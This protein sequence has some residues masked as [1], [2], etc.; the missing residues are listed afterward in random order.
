MYLLDLTSA[1]YT[2]VALYTVSGQKLYQLVRDKLSAG[3]HKLEL[4][5]G[6]RANGLYIIKLHSDTGTAT[7]ILSVQH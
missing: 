6:G 7:K 4:D 3:R 1:S 5:A 2:D